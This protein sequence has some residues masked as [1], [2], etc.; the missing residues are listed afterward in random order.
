[1]AK[2]VKRIRRRRQHTIRCDWCAS[3]K[4]TS[5][6]DTKTCSGRCRQRLAFFIKT[7]GYAPE[8]AP[9]EK[10]AQD[11]IDLEI[12]RLFRE[13]SRRRKKASE[14]SSRPIE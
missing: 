13:E 5:R 12:V 1:V 9:G 11:A 7:C 6:S 2:K 14:L 4:E 8:T 3:I 10:T